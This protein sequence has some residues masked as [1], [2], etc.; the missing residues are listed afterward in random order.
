MAN[1]N[2]LY[3]SQRGFTLIELL[4]AVGIMALVG[5]LAS[6]M[7]NTSLNNKERIEQRQ[8]QLEELALALQIIRRDLEQL[9]P[10][11]PRDQH[12]G[13]FQAR[14]RGEQIG[15]Y[16][17]LEFVHAGRRVLPGQ[18]LQSRLER[19]RYR[20]EDGSLI[21]YSAA[22]ADP[23]SNTEW[24]RQVLLEDVGRFLVEFY[25]D[26]RWTSFWPPNTQLT[27][28]QPEG[29][30]LVMDVAQWPDITMNVLLPETY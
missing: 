29:L 16:S 27:A 5:S 7:L 11:V 2:Q 18:A 25:F 10:R 8:Q 12:G 6:I 3:P 4:I 9:T 17:E 19:V 26:K 23:T 20:W 15:D 28:S 30:R 14:L 22:V 13:P 1:R 21:R 24:Q